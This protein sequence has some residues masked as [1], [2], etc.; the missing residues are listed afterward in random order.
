MGSSKEVAVSAAYRLDP[1]V[2]SQTKRYGYH[3]ARPNT[4]RQ[5]LGRVLRVSTAS[6]ARYIR[7]RRNWTGR[8]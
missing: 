3:M 5:F 7:Y 2:C 8:V 1:G 4:R 6:Q